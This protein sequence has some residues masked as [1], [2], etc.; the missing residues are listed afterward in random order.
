MFVFPG[1][2]SNID[3]R[4]KKYHIQTEVNKV[5]GISRI[6]TVVYLSGMI[7]LSVSSEIKGDD[8]V[9]REAAVSSIRK[10]H[11]KVIR[12]LI[13][14]QLAPQKFVSD[15]DS[16]DFVGMYGNNRIFLCSNKTVSGAQ[17]IFRELLTV[18]EDEK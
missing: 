15:K 6:N 9:S 10:Q 1:F 7:F 18:P 17:D 13:S 3:H 11:N 8:A 4:N 14:D 16:V 2:N 12:D 5:D